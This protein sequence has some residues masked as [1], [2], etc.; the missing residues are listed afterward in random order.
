MFDVAEREDATEVDAF[1]SLLGLSAFV[2]VVHD[3]GIVPGVALIELVPFLI[4]CFSGI[5]D[6]H[7][8]V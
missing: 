2:N 4:D 5:W 1:A 8:L 6:P 3:G 7:G